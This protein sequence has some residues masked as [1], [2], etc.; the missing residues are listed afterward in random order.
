[1]KYS[2]I[3][4]RSN[5]KSL[6]ATKFQ[7]RLSYQQIQFNEQ[8]FPYF[9]QGCPQHLTYSIF[10]KVLFT[11]IQN[12]KTTQFSKI[13]KCINKYSQNTSILDISASK[14]KIVIFMMEVLKLIY[15]HNDNFG[16]NSSHKKYRI[17]ANSQ[18]L[19]QFACIFNHN[20]PHYVHILL[21]NTQEVHMQ[22][23]IT[24]MFATR[25]IKSR[26]KQQINIAVGFAS[27]VHYIT[28]PQK[29]VRYY[30]VYA[31]QTFF[32]VYK[33]TLLQL[34]TILQRTNVPIQFS[35]HAFYKLQT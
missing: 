11:Q 17:Y 35:L 10:I 33:C 4:D 12:Q 7:S 2:T 23:I 28:E 29:N 22:I 21:C 8:Y 30:K 18:Q 5:T 14:I 26:P 16:S 15:R 32:I 24:S 9:I 27:N 34:D 13:K 3:P 19:C 25:R 20:F 1:M 6:S 31:M